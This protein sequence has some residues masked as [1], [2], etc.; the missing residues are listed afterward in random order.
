[1]EKKLNYPLW[2]DMV[3]S[4]EEDYDSSEEEL[5]ISEEELSTDIN[6]INVIYVENINKKKLN[7]KKVIDK[8]K[9]KIEEINKLNYISFLMLIISLIF[10]LIYYRFDY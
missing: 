3:D 1:M 5:E 9:E 2:A 6:N 10:C 4:S 7:N 8:N